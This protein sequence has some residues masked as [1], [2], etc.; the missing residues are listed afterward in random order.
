MGIDLASVLLK[1]MSFVWTVAGHNGAAAMATCSQKCSACQEHES[2]QMVS[3]RVCT[4]DSIC[5]PCDSGKDFESQCDGYD[6][7]YS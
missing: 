6:T 5:T 3:M 2:G 4:W 7:Q 1:T